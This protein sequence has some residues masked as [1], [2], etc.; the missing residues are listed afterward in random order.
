[1]TVK[2]YKNPLLNLTNK[3]SSHILSNE[4]K[5]IASVT[6]YSKETGQPFSEIY[7][8]ALILLSYSLSHS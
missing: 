1:M 4:V 7:I 8:S 5:Y 6:V 3:K 2:H